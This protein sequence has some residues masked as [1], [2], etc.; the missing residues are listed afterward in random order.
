MTGLTGGTGGTGGTGATGMTGMTGGTGNTGANG[1]TVN[2]QTGSYTTVL[3]DAGKQILFPV[4][5]GIGVVY[6]IDSNANVP[7]ALGTQIWF[8]NRSSNNLSIAITAD[9]L[10]L[11]GTTTTGNRVLQPNSIAVAVKEQSTVWLIGTYI[12]TAL[13]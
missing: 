7:Y 3:S 10:I 9:T 6:T 12:G 8:A 2:S 1:L 4:G 11:A 13:A 5:S